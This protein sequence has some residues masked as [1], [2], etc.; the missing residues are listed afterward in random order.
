MQRLEAR[1][2]A[3][4]RRRPRASVKD[5]TDH[6]LEQF[7]LV[8]LGYLPDDAELAAPITALE[9]KHAEH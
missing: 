1:V 2:T 8:E 9:E 5:M 3:L 6:D 7:L 4:E